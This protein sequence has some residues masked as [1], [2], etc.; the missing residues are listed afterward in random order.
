[1]LGRSV[2][3]FNMELLKD[4][5]VGDSHSSSGSWFHSV[6]AENL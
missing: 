4:V 2:Y 3:L 6:A 5:R 1:M